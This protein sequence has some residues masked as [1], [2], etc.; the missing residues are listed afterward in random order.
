MGQYKFSVSDRTVHEG[1]D[2]VCEVCGIR[3]KHK[4]PYILYHNKYTGNVVCRKCVNKEGL[5][6]VPD[7]SVED[8]GKYNGGRRNFHGFN[9]SNEDNGDY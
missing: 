1:I 3:R 2:Y 9:L 8:K 5:S 7:D 4:D 6:L